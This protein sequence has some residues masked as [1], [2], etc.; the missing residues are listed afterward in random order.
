MARREAGDDLSVVV[1]A[2]DLGID[3][4]S[5]LSSSERRLAEESD[6]TTWRWHDC[7]EEDFSD[8]EQL[9]FMHLEGSDKV[10]NR[11]LRIVGKFFPGSESSSV[12]LST[13]FLLVF[14][15]SLVW[16]NLV[17]FVYAFD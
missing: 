4:R 12:F 17:R 1:L 2:S 5:L 10:G 9:Q 3:G 6:E 11:I 7:M 14:C 13:I 15:L 8:L 16:F